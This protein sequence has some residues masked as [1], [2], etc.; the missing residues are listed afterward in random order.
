MPRLYFD[1]AAGTPID[2]RVLA[3][4]EKLSKEFWANPGSIHEEG[5]AAQ[6]ALEEARSRV[7]AWCGVKKY[8]VVFTAGGTE[9]NNLAIRGVL[10]ALPQKS[11]H[12]ITSTME[13]SSVLAPLAEY[14]RRGFSVTEL[15]PDSDGLIS[16]DQ[17]MAAMRENTVLVTLHLANSEIGV[18]QPI[19]DIA[20]AVRALRDAKGRVYPYI[21]TDACQAARFM[22][23]F[24]E[25]LS[26][27][28]MSVSGAKV[29]GPHGSGAL[30][31]RAGTNCAPL[32][33]GGGQ[34]HGLRSG[35]QNLP[36]IGGFA[37]ALSICVEERDKESE[38]LSFLRD[39]CIALIQKIPGAVING[40]IKRRLPHNVHASFHGISGERLVIE[41]DRRGIA[42][43]TGSAC[44]AR[45]KSASHVLKALAPHEP[46]RAHGALR[47]TLPRGAAHADVRF[48]VAELSDIL[49]KCTHSPS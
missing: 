12:V 23:L 24:L 15:M 8:E 31:V 14:E 7:A 48:V 36:A 43:A 46:W 6:K 32:I 27:D 4:M 13:H 2:G 41:L 25:T 3:V 22:P 21:H 19:R 33:F 11:G 10:D 30:I 45:T 20:R 38:E 49:Q 44:S 9:S 40:S 47:L 29:Y 17:V 35:T 28:L 39:E 26:V 1:S 34:E 18:I 5:E 42:A 37:E 16:V